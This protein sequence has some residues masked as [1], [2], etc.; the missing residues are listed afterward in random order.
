[1]MEGEEMFDVTDTGNLI[2][3]LAA[4]DLKELRELHDRIVDTEQI[5]RA[6]IRQR[7]AQQ[8]RDARLRERGLCVA[9]ATG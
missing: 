4:I 8:R 6:V 7:E 2:Q 3:R 5:T 1:M 9:G